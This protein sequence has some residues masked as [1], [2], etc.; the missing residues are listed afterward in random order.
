M[1]IIQKIDTD[2]N[3]HKRTLYSTGSGFKP[4]AYYQQGGFITSLIDFVKDNKELLSSGAA[5]VGKVVDLGK[6]IADTMK[7][8]KELEKIRETNTKN[9]RK[10]YTM[11]PEQE[12]ALKSV[13]SGF[14]TFGSERQHKNQ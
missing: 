10:E 7:T 3:L 12:E 13:G 6:S 11:T 2:R 9:K 5:A 14:A 4:P 8:A 1:T